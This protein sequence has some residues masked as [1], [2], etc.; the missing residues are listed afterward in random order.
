MNTPLDLI[1]L[2]VITIDDG[3][4]RTPAVSSP[5]TDNPAA[6]FMPIH[7]AIIAFILAAKTTILEVAGGLI[8]LALVIAGFH[9]IT[10]NAK[11]GK[12]AIA[13]AVIGL[14]IVIFSYS[15]LSFVCQSAGSSC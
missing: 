8:V 1:R 12:T 11:Q 2:A 14:I 7:D 3:A 9:Y 15:I 4:Y 5:T 13:A 6:A 10:G